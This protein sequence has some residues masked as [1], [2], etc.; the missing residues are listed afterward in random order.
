MGPCEFWDWAFASLG[1]STCLVCLLGPISA[2]NVSAL[3]GIINP[4]LGTHYL[5]R[6]SSCNGPVGIGLF[7]YSLPRYKFLGG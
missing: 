6:A 7:I 1:D 5:L 3:M 2:W 4:F